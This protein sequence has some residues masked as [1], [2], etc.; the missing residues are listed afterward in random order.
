VR[1]DFGGTNYYV[2]IPGD[3]IRDLTNYQAAASAIAGATDMS[4]VFFWTNRVDIPVSE[5]MDETSMQTLAATCQRHPDYKKPVFRLACWLYPSYEAAT[6]AHAFIMP[7]VEWP[8][9][10]MTTN[11]ATN[12]VKAP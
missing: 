11:T 7:G 3:K 9:T 12:D 10:E 1:D 8:E 4:I 2:L 6:N 5:W